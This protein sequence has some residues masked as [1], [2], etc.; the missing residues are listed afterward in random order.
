[1]KELKYLV[2]RRREM[3]GDLFIHRMNVLVFVCLGVGIR[4]DV[5]GGDFIR[6]HGGR[7]KATNHGFDLIYNR[8]RR[9]RYGL[10]YVREIP[11]PRLIFVRICFRR[12]VGM[13]SISWWLWFRVLEPARCKNETAFSTEKS[14]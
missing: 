2:S 3:R 6:G 4:W 8:R 10:Y 12:K 11:S 14:R 13:V 7:G 5:D 9:V 1:M